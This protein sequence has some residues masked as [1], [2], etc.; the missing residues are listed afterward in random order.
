[1]GI[2]LEIEDAVHDMLHH[3]GPGDR[4]VLV[5]MPDDENRDIG[6]LAARHHRRGA[7][8]YL[9]DAAGGGGNVRETH[10]LNRIEDEQVGPMLLHGA[11]TVSMS[12]S[13]RTE[14]LS[15]CTPSRSARS[16]I[17]L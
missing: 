10:R 17:C 3:L 1:M 13:H 4:P 2:P 7:F 9:G 8:P 6:R 12:V 5:D 11:M 15:L 14:R 16:L